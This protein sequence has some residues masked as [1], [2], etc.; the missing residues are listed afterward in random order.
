VIGLYVLSNHVGRHSHVVWWGSKEIRTIAR[1]S[2]FNELNFS[3]SECWVLGVGRTI[4]LL[5]QIW[6]IHRAIMCVFN[7]YF[8]LHTRYIVSEVSKAT[9][10]TC[11][12]ELGEKIYTKFGD[13]RG[14]SWNLWNLK[15]VSDT[16][17]RFETT[18]LQRLKFALIDT[19][20]K[21]REGVGQ[22]SKSVFTAIT[23]APA[24]CFRFPI[25]RSDLD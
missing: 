18:A 10:V 6:R 14:P 8:N 2:H 7:A 11:F 22:I 16:F 4:G 3:I 17:L 13:V 19:L 12:S 9:E 15:K 21:I 5:Y 20:C 1:G 24:T 23:Y 25:C